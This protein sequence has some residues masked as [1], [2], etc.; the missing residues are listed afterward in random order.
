MH[1]APL[2]RRSIW[3]STALFILCLIPAPSGAQEEP[4]AP[5]PSPPPP[6]P[7]TADHVIDAPGA[8]GWSLSRDG[9]KALWLSREVNH[10]EDRFD[11]Q[12]MLLDVATAKSRP[13]TVGKMRVSR[14]T[15]TIE[16][17]AV[18]YL[19]GD[20]APE[21]FPATGEEESGAQ[22]W[23]LDLTGGAPRPL[24]A[25]PFGLESFEV[26][27]DGSIIYSARGRR[28]VRELELKKRKDDTIVVEDP[29]AFAE[30]TGAIYS[31]DLEKK[32]TRRLVGSADGPIEDYLISPDGRFAITAHSRDP[33]HPAE[34]KH[35][36]AWFLRDLEPGTSRELFTDT[37]MRPNRAAWAWDSKQAYFVWPHS[38]RDGEDMAAISLIR[39]LDPA[40]GAVTDFPLDWERGLSGGLGTITSNGLI[41]HLASGVKPRLARY[42]PNGREGIE[43]GERGGI[44]SFVK[45]RNAN[46]CLIATGDSS[47]PTRIHI[48]TL[49]GSTL[50]LGEKVWSPEFDPHPIA[51][52][53]IVRWTGAL[54][55][56]IEGIVYYP[57]DYVE[58]QRYPIIA[59]THGGPFGADY[60]RFESSWAYAPHLYCQQGAMILMTNYHGSSD[61]GLEFGES[62]RGKYYQLEIEDI[63]SG[64]QAL[65]DQGKADPK[66]VGLIGWSNGA[67]LSV[68]TLTHRHRYAPGYDFTFLACAPGAGDVNWTSDYGNCAFGG[69]FDD[70]YLGGPPWELPELYVERSPLFEV[71]RVTTPTLLFHGTEDTAVPTSQSWEWYR[72]MHAVGKAP[73]R[74]LLFPGEPH[75]LQ[76][77]SHQRR[78]LVEELAWFDQYF[79]K[80]KK[81]APEPPVGSPIDLALKSSEAKRDGMRRLGVLAES[82]L[83]PETVPFDA[84]GNEISRFEVTIQQWREF[85]PLLA[86]GVPEVLRSRPDFPA[87]GLSREGVERYIAWLTDRTGCRWRLPTEEEFEKLA[88]SAGPAENDLDWWVGYPPSPIDAPRFVAMVKGL[89]LENALHAVGKH[90]PGMIE[91]A[92]Q[93]HAIYDLGGNAAE[94]LRRSDGSFGVKSAWALASPDDAEPTPREPDGE[95]IGLRLVRENPASGKSTTGRRERF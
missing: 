42:T 39:V 32:K 30:P 81:D 55:E 61:Y 84:L 23:R 25:V 52:T 37:K 56:E 22:L 21:G 44:Y 67:I 27:E 34:G 62:I 73:V 60:D 51:R 11:S 4:G 87:T 54:D 1:R 33:S 79:F 8:S 86:Y 89:G 95:F 18:L 45:A 7:W 38:A 59:M 68:A 82:S 40:T 83:V 70:Y 6:T 53:E 3:I 88:K 46:T 20:P 43:G 57:A 85:D 14:P 71:E 93:K 15:F 65:V 72:A 66:R 78:K 90:P 91:Q 28:T 63:L 10:K 58:G 77:P 74:L 12:L 64:I 69:T 17:D 92:G 2:H 16:G 75:G 50:T 47:T 94:P 29:E 9:S 48:A 36:P 5:P 26:R 24:T 31:L 49:E 80:K 41:T 13:L 35:P 19:S 76:K